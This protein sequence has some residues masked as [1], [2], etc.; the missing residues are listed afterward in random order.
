M[1]MAHEPDLFDSLEGVVPVR[2]VRL[3]GRNEDLWRLGTAYRQAADILAQL[4]IQDDFRNI[5]SL[6]DLHIWDAD[7][8]ALPILQ[9]YR[10]SI[11]L[12]LKAACKRAAQLV[13]R[14]LEMGFGKEARPEDLDKQ[15]TKTHGLS[16]LVDLFNEISEGLAAGDTAKLDSET[17]HVLKQLHQ[18][19]ARGTAFRYVTQY[20]RGA[21]EEVAIRPG[22]MTLDVGS[23][24]VRL[25]DAAKLLDDGVSGYLDAYEEWL[26]NM[27]SEYRENLGWG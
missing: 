18:W 2:L 5:E 24:L 17:A 25:G 16:G 22:E 12:L 7:S 3:G 6:R 9:T 13:G 19:D 14:G 11:E 26:D 20:D 15:L 1:D 23:A 10:H 4:W 8:L 21:K 27:W